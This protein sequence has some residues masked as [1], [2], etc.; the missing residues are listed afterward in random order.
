MPM[1][2]AWILVLLMAPVPAVAQEEDPMA[3]QRCIWRCLAGSPGAASAQ[4]NQCVEDQCTGIEEPVQSMAPAS[5]GAPV[6]PPQVWSAGVAS[7]G[8]HR[9][10]GIDR[11]QGQGFY[12]LCSAQG[13]S[14]FTLSGLPLDP[15]QMQVIIGD[16]RYLVPFDAARGDLSVNIPP[17]T[18]FIEA[19]AAGD[20]MD[21]LTPE[22]YSVLS[23]SL[24]GARASLAQAVAGC[25]P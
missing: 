16:V 20:R 22:G 7:D 23:I 5:D 17:A 6:A 14:Y 9:F 15:G 13:A 8:V 1:R 24:M 19:V 10:A 12:Y 21:V 2:F 4:Y 11:G 18:P 25:F 3:L